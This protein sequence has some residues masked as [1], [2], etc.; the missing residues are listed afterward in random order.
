MEQDLKNWFANSKISQQNRSF[1][2]LL[3]M[4][5]QDCLFIPWSAAPTLPFLSRWSTPPHPLDLSCFVQ[6]VMGPVILGWQQ[7]YSLGAGWPATFLMS[8]RRTDPS[9]AAPAASV[10]EGGELNWASS[11]PQPGPSPAEPRRP[12]PTLQ[13]IR[14][15]TVWGRQPRS[16][17]SCLS[18]WRK[19][20]WFT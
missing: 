16:V 20:D 8:T 17:Q 6:W 5:V 11:D 2:F 1:L 4:C 12:P 3:S 13:W 14:N 9:H 15:T 7:K 10:P 18:L 19:A